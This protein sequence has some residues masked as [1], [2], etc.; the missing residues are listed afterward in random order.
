VDILITHTDGISQEG[1]L[2]PLIDSLKKCGMPAEL[3]W[4]FFL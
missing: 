1:L 2:V 4:I 3:I